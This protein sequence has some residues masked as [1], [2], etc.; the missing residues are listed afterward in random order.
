[1]VGDTLALDGQPEWTDGR[2]IHIVGEH[3]VLA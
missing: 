3:K 1:M 2:G